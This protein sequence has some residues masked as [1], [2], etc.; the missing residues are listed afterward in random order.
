M[1]RVKEA[2]DA[3]GG[4]AHG[5]ELRAHIFLPLGDVLLAQRS[6]LRL[7][8]E[9]SPLAEDERHLRFLVD[10]GHHLPEVVRKA[11]AVV[12]EHPPAPP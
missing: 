11:V 7:V 5:S 4:V 8:F 3:A 10:F 6:S 1:V 9:Q 12:T 2:A